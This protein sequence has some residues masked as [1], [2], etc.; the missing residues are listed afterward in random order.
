[1]DNRSEVR[2]FL[3][4]RRAR[5]TPE[6][7]GLLVHGMRRVPGLRRGELAVLAGVSVEY[8][9]RIER[10]NLNGV[11]EGVLHALAGALRLDDAERAH[12]LDLARASGAATKQSRRPGQQRIRPA[13]QRLLDAMTGFP[14]VVQNGRLDILAASPL[15]FALYSEIF[16][17]PQRPAN[18]ARFVFLDSRS[19]AFY[20]DWE[21]TAH[22][23]V[24]VLR[25]EA[26]RNP[27]DRAL[28]DLIGE[29]STRS[30]EFRTRWAA[31]NV[32]Q[33]RAGTK[34]LHHPVVGDLDVTFEALDLTADPG[35][36]LVAY[37]AE[38]GS[39]S[40]D[41]LSLL[42]GWAATRDREQ[43]L[44]TAD[45]TANPVGA[46]NSASLGDL[47]VFVDHS[48]ESV[49]SADLDIASL[50]LV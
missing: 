43:T 11:S 4:S 25:A 26:G 28:T 14:A 37:T 47:R 48:A 3:S 34:R 23:A 44:P 18:H 39:P 12:L 49:T 40:H 7:A 50:G 8:Y 33:H 13:V 29:L 38:P 45:T 19:H 2:E 24:A 41:A 36:Q 15:G 32:R 17:D 20:R 30:D 1:M 21:A 22:D 27:Y 6:Q 31:H 35:L 10:G 5:I 46:R 42:A 9:T 16:V